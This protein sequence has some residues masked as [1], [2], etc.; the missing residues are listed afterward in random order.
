MEQVTTA[1][2]GSPLPV[3]RCSCLL[4]KP[5]SGKCVLRCRA[6]VVRYVTTRRLQQGGKT[7][8]LMKATSENDTRAQRGVDAS[9]R[10]GQDSKNLWR[11]SA[12][13]T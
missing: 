10:I 2:S 6:L 13:T 5:S 8:W 7:T 12:E 1:Q 4:M 3:R 9:P 11:P